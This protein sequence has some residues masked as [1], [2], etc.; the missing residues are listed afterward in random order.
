[1]ANQM[2]HFLSSMA[3]LDPRQSF[4]VGSIIIGAN[5]VEET[6]EAMQAN[7]V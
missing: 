5:G 6:M 1:M 3:L 2:V 4:M 7:P